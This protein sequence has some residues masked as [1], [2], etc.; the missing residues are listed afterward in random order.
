MQSGKILDSAITASSV[1]GSRYKPYFGR[2]KK[3]A[4]LCSWTPTEA[5]R[6]GSWLQVDLGRKTTITG[7]ATQGSC[8]G[9]EWPTSYSLSYSNDGFNWT[10]YEE[11]GNAKVIKCAKHILAIACCFPNMYGLWHIKAV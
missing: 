1:Y 11:S 4:N 5:G 10:D 6:V 8:Y 7:L 2:L 9:G 3:S